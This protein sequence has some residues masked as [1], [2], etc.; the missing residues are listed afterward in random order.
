M[1]E[2]VPRANVQCVH[3]SGMNSTVN[4]A[5]KESVH[6]Q[7]AS[8]APVLWVRIKAYC[9]R[10]AKVCPLLPQGLVMIIKLSQKSQ[11]P[12]PLT[13]SS[14]FSRITAFGD[15]QRGNKTR[16]TWIFLYSSLALTFG[17]QSHHTKVTFTQYEHW[18]Q[19]KDSKMISIVFFSGLY[20]MYVS[21]NST[22]Q[23][24]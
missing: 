6:N 2:F 22:I 12:H 3:S 11:L 23:A 17:I 9:K 8:S 7:S 16:N 20:I 4:S 19:V 21:L 5:G 15:Q 10:I 14:V 18:V 13:L 1:V 24:L